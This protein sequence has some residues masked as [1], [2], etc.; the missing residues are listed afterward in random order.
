[1][2]KCDKE[3]TVFSRVVGYYGEVSNWNLGKKEEFVDRSRFNK[4][5]EEV[6]FTPDEIEEQ[7]LNHDKHVEA[8]RKEQKQFGSM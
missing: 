2:A 4:A 7:K 1:M 3:C 5:G 6:I 8:I